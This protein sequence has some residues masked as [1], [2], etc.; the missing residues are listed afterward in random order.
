MEY[1]SD[2]SETLSL[3]KRDIV[4]NIQP[5][6]RTKNKGI[7]MTTYTFGRDHDYPIPISDIHSSVSH[8]HA[9]LTID[10]DDWVLIDND[11][12]NGTYIE[13]NGLFR[14]CKK[15]KV[16]PDTWIRLGEEGHRGYYFKAYRVLRQNNYKEDFEE[17]YAVF[18]EYEEAKKKLETH[19]RLSKFVSP[20]LMLVFYG[21]SY[22]IPV[23]Q[24]NSDLSRLFILAPGLCAPFITDK[25][26]NNLNNNVKNLHQRLICPKCR[27]PLSKH[28]I[29]NREDPICHA[30]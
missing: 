11:S 28:D 29:I 10:N 20:I 13:E 1:T 15:A 6:S 5:H 18:Q 14:R 24:N 2:R 4:L 22:C 16:R 25:L 12:T 8:T 27:R 9:T 7:Y 30:H 26:L 21:L 17:L 19:M 23:I 3:S